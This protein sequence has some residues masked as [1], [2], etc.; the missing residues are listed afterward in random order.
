VEVRGKPGVTWD[1]SRAPPDAFPFKFEE[2]DID[3]EIR[4]EK[5]I[6]LAGVSRMISTVDGQNYREIPKFWD[7]VNEQR[8]LGKLF[9]DY[10]KSGLLQGAMVGA[11]LEYDQANERL[12]YLIGLEPSGTSDLE[13]MTV[14]TIPAQTWAVFRDK[15][16][17]PASIQETWKRIYGEWFPASQYE[18]SGGPELEVYPEEDQPGEMPYEIWIPVKRK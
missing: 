12:L 14:K 3:Y 7:E 18:H 9:A 4:N 16:P 11:I 13:G 17:M 1:R 8:P 15:G 5:E 10:G 6:V 2:Y